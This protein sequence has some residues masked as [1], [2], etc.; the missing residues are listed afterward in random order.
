MQFE[1]HNFSRRFSTNFPSIML[2]IDYPQFPFYLSIRLNVY[3]FLFYLFY[4]RSFHILSRFF[5]ILYNFH[6][7]LCVLVVLLS[8]KFSLKNHF[9]YCS[10]SFSRNFPIHNHLFSLNSVHLVVVV[11]IIL[12]CR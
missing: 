10:C 6:Y 7:P 3:F 12:C 9:T 2:V 11:V 1:I 5:L 8:K 4:P